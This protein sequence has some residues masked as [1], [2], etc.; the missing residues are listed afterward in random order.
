[1]NYV[2]KMTRTLPKYLFYFFI[3]V[4]VF[5]AFSYLLMPGIKEPLTSIEKK[6]I[7]KKIVDSGRDVLHA[8]D[9]KIKESTIEEDKKLTELNNII[10]NNHHIT[11]TK[12]KNNNDSIG[13]TLRDIQNINDKINDTAT[14]KEIADY[15]DGKISKVNENVF[16]THRLMTTTL[17]NQQQETTLVTPDHTPLLTDTDK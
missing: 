12:T 11:L 2:Q 14:K 1:M 17:A 3:I 10:K 16:S 6:Y 15:V 4:L 7:D 8:M 5:N 13:T 9:V